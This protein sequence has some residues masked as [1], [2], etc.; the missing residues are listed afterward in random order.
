V[1]SCIYFLKHM[2]NL[3]L[4]WWKYH[5]TCDGGMVV[6]AAP[7]KTTRTLSFQTLLEIEALKRSWYRCHLLKKWHATNY[8]IKCTPKICKRFLAN[9]KKIIVSD[10]SQSVSFSLPFFFTEGIKS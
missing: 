10:I 1:S 7:E 9:T 2:L 5:F 4:I 6:Y 3:I 8:I